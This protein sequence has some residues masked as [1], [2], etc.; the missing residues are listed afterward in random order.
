MCSREHTLKFT[1]TCFMAQNLVS[2]SKCSVYTWERYIFCW[3][4]VECCINVNQVM[5]VDSV[6]HVY[7]MLADFLCLSIIERGVLKSDYNCGFVYFSLQLYQLLL[8]V[9]FMVFTNILF[10]LRSWYWR[11]PFKTYIPGQKVQIKSKRAVFCCIH[12]CMNNFNC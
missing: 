8:H 3:Y 12:F 5:L 10:I 11:C 4:W 7:Y 6:V 9:F 1:N 2:L